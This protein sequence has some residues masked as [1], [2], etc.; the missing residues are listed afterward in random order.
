MSVCPQR[1]LNESIALLLLIT[2]RDESEEERI[3]NNLSEL[4]D[5]IRL[6]PDKV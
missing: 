1:I 5:L 3:A 2:P 4:E 6:L